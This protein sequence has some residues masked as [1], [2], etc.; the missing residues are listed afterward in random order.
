MT[1]VLILLGSLF[2][3]AIGAFVAEPVTNIGKAIFS[4][5]GKYDNNKN[6]IYQL[7]TMCLWPWVLTYRLWNARK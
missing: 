3:L 7:F 1:S 5:F 2:Y 4:W 6:V